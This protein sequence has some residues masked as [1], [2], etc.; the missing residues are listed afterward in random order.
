LKH[1]DLRGLDF[2]GISGFDGLRGA[3]VSTSQVIDLAPL[4]AAE[5]GM[6]V[7]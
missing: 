3:T 4:F 2:R 5:L 6:L 7:G 1:V